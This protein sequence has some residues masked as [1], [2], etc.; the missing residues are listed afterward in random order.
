MRLGVSSPLHDDTEF[1]QLIPSDQEAVEPT[2][3]ISGSFL[4]D[5]RDSPPK[6][7]KNLC[8]FFLARSSRRCRIAD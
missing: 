1:G 6:R 3:P 8:G 2:N 4:S 7:A 5:L